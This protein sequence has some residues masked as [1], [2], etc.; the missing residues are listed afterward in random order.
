MIDALLDWLAGVLA[1]AA[2]ALT[3]WL[4]GLGPDEDWA[5]A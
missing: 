4:G 2:V 3:L 1:R 5:E